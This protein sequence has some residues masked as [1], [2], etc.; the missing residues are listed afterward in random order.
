MFV[1]K[2]HNYCNTVMK[3]QWNEKPVL[4]QEAYILLINS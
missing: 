3:T 4:T 1:K 2:K